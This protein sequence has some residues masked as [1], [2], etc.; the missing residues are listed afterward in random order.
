[1]YCTWKNTK[2]KISKTK[3]STLKNRP[4]LLTIAGILS[5]NKYY[6]PCQFWISIVGN[7]QWVDWNSF[8]SHKNLNNVIGPKIRNFTRLNFHT[9]HLC[10]VL[11]WLHYSSN[12]SWIIFYGS[13]NDL[14][15]GKAFW[16]YLRLLGLPLQSSNIWSVTLMSL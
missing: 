2:C 8:N 9:L 1:M 7:L 16:I 11:Q 12:F 15:L 4:N 6:M 13:L 14:V 3:I 10:A 5:N